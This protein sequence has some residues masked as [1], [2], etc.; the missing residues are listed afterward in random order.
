MNTYI[1]K[2][3]NYTKLFAIMT[4]AALFAVTP[5]INPQE[6]EA[7]SC[8]PSLPMIATV[9]SINSSFSDFYP[10]KLT[11]HIFLN[12]T[13]FTVSPN[14]NLQKSLVTKYA[15]G[16]LE[17]YIPT[18]FSGEII[19]EDH[20]SMSENIHSDYSYLVQP[21]DYLVKT[22]PQSLSACGGPGLMSIMRYS[23]IDDEMQLIASFFRSHPYGAIDL[24]S[25]SITAYPDTH[26][27]S[28]ISLMIN[29]ISHSL[30]QGESIYPNTGEISN[31]IQEIELSGFSLE[32][33]IWGSMPSL[34]LVFI[35]KNEG[36]LIVD[37]KPVAK[38]IEGDLCQIT[39]S[40]LVRYGRRG[41]DVRQVQNCLN[42]LGYNTGTADGIYGPNTYRGVT[43]FQ[44]SIGGIQVD[45]IV[46]PVTVQYLNQL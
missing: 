4:M 20:I 33:G 35:Y 14:P 37:P 39:Y 38:P 26:D 22:P 44:R 17:E 13:Y 31:T 43:E 27:A 6:A 28:R 16:T 42:N 8:L 29:G 10:L 11:D 41:N 18:Y 3:I 45:G 15:E 36:D 24:G 30:R 25:Q 2:Q 5:I 40:Q 23:P 21:G 7:L 12:P 32:E 9:E 1:T 34:G 46:G 19:P